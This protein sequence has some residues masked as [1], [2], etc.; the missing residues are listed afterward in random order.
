[1]LHPAAVHFPI[2][3]LSLG[4]V[5]AFLSRR[6]ARPELSFAASW[7]LWLGTLSAWVAAGLGVLA[8]STAPHVPAAWEALADHKALG[9]WTAGVFTVLALWRWRWPRKGPALFLVAWFAAA[10]LIFATA[11]EGG[12]VVFTHGMG[13]GAPD[14]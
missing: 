13:V 4:L 10:G 5:P 12:E 2:A 8:E 7:L 14:K 3:L 9:L 11:K 1:L 6:G